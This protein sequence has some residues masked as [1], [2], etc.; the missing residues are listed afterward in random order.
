[1]GKNIKTRIDIDALRGSIYS[2]FKSQAEFADALKWRRQKVNEILNGK[3]VVDENEIA[4]MVNVLEIDSPEVVVN[5]F[6]PYLSPK[7][8]KTA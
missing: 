4:E 2:K 1:M 3:W 7:G 6:F 8:T 5:I